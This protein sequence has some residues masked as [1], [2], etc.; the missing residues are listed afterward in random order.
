MNL[1]KRCEIVF[2]NVKNIRK[3]KFFNYW[4][5][6]ALVLHLLCWE[7]MWNWVLKFKKIIRKLVSFKWLNFVCVRHVHEHTQFFGIAELLE[8]LGRWVTE[9]II[10]KPEQSLSV[11]M[12]IRTEISFFCFSL[13]RH[14]VLFIGNK[15]CEWNVHESWKKKQTAGEQSVT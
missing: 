10:S 9:E 13:S 2:W 1:G 6:F 8:I 5:L 7:K 15:N 3:Y 12:D 11:G 14:R 4:I